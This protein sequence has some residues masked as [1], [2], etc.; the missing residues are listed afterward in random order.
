MTGGSR[1]DDEPL[2]SEEMIERAR[3]E[4]AASSEELLQ[5][6]KESVAEVPEIEGLANIEIDIPVASE[7][8]D[9][10]PQIQNRPRRVHRPST[11]IPQGPFSTDRAPRAIVVAI[12][13]VILLIT[14]GVLVAT[15]SGTGGP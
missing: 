4:R 15:V 11:A 10:I 8:P 14:I 7:F 2:S 12:A 13:A 5:E 1:R 6:A 9:P 3:G